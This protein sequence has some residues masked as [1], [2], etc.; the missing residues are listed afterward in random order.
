MDY[1]LDLDLDLEIYQQR[2]IYRVLISD[3]KKLR[4]NLN[5]GLAT[6]TMSAA[7]QYA[8]ETLEYISRK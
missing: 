5:K 7:E 2:K 4:Q 3:K 8:E 1:T 6:T